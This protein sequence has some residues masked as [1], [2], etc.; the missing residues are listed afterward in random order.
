[1][2]CQIDVITKLAPVVAM[3]AGRSEMLGKVEKAV[4][5]TQNDDVCGCDTGCCEVSV[6]RSVNK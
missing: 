1:M 6:M 5:V 2:D 4:R 3:F